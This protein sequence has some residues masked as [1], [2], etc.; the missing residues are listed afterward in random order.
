[1]KKQHASFLVIVGVICCFVTVNAGEVKEGSIVCMGRKELQEY[2]IYIQEGKDLFAA[3]MR[4]RAKCYVKKGDSPVIKLEETKNAYQIEL[5]SGHK[6]W[7]QPE[8]YT[9]SSFSAVS[10]QE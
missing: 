6:V 10:E 4:D 5:L 9:H 2:I 8:S 1:M 3:A 7:V